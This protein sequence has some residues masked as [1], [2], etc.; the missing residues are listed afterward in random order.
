MVRVVAVALEEATVLSLVLEQRLSMAAELLTPQVLMVVEL[1]LLTLLV[2]KFL[3]VA[4][5]Q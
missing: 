5:E 2:T 1:V 4:A 3:L